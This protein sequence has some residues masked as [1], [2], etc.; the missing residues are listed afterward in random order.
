M[1]RTSVYY[2]YTHT[3]VCECIQIYYVK[4]LMHVHSISILPQL[5]VVFGGSGIDDD[6]LL[7]VRGYHDVILIYKTR[8]HFMAALCMPHT[9]RCHVYEVIILYIILVVL[10]IFGF[11]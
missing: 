8:S 2:S 7:H 4:K 11:S 5:V 1:L 10:F 3:Y 9:R 6:L